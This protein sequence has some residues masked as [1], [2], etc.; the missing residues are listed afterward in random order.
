MG[1]KREKNVACV[2]KSGHHSEILIKC[3]C[4]IFAH[5]ITFN[6]VC[7]YSIRWLGNKKNPLS[8]ADE[9]DH[10]SS[11]PDVQ[12]CKC[13]HARKHIESCSGYR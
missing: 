11:R 2:R 4:N 12:Q 6:I 5:S 13:C 8:H 7:M 9:R 10:K 1:E 3:P